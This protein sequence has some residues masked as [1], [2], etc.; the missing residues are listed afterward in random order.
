MGGVDKSDQLYGYNNF[1]RKWWK[2]V[3][4]HLLDVTLVNAYVLYYKT[5]EG[6][7]LSHMDFRIEVAKGLIGAEC[8]TSLQLAPVVD[9]PARLIGHNHFPEPSGQHDC[10]VCS[11]RK[12]GKRKTTTY[13][14]C[15]C[16]VPLCVYPCFKTYHTVMHY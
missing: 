3:Y 14:C 6:K 1:S 9:S 4:F 13:I 10:E 2:R 15:S 16:K 8:F 12:S 11:N 5:C 7:V